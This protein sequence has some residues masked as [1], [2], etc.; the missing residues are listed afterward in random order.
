METTRTRINYRLLG[1]IRCVKHREKTQIF[2]CDEDRKSGVRINWDLYGKV[3]EAKA[4][5]ELG[6]DC[7]L[8]GHLDNDIK[9]EKVTFKKIFS[10]IVNSVFNT[11]M[12]DLI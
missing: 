8:V 4:K 10:G 2:E 3:L 5:K 1:K 6:D 9:K 11:T 12:G 7:V